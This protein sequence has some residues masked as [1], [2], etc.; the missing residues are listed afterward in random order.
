MHTNMITPVQRSEHMVATEPRKI[1]DLDLF[2]DC[3]RAERRQINSLTTHLRV[4][5]DRVLMR[6]GRAPQEFIIIGSGQVQVTR[7]TDQGRSV[8]SELGSG[9]ILGERALLMGTH[10]TATA[11]ATTDL[12]VF[13]CSVSE[14]RTMLRIAPSVARKVRQTLHQRIEGLADAA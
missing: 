5:K 13:V 1:E 6:E 10:R 12:T 2:S 4:P 8:V 14:F 3:T 9:E 11:T 7:D